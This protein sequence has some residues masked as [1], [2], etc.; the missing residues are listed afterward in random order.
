VLQVEIGGVL[1]RVGGIAK[2]SGMIHPNMATMLSVV[3]CDAAVEPGLW[4]ALFKRSAVK[5]FN[6]ARQLSLSAQQPRMST[7]CM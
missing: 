2:G 4:R 7:K 3:T 5:S 6:Q 1:V